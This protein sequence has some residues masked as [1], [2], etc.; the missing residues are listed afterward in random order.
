MIEDEGDNGGV[1]GIDHNEYIR[2][3][4]LLPKHSILLVE[5]TALY[6]DCPQAAT[7][8]HSEKKREQIDGGNLYRHT[9]SHRS[10]VFG[11]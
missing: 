7:L 5:T 3:A 6:G 8:E 2:P 10:I 11:K 1:M 9:V 4:P